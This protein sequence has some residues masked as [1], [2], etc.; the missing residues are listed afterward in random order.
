MMLPEVV[1]KI[2][3]WFPALED[4]RKTQEATKNL[5]QQRVETLS[6]HGAKRKAL[7]SS[8]ALAVYGRRPRSRR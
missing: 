1:A 3:W 7:Q 8:A 2:T 6:Y 4:G 5:V